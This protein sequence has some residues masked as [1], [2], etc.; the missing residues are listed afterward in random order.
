ML[1]MSIGNRFIRVNG[2]DSGVVHSV[3]MGFCTLY[4]IYR[5]IAK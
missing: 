5:V 3:L 4:I 1:I 2:S